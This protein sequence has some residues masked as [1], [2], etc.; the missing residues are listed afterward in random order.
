MDFL[1]WRMS[2]R[3]KKSRGLSNHSI[4]PQTSV[5]PLNSPEINTSYTFVQKGFE[6]LWQAVKVRQNLGARAPAADFAIFRSGAPAALR[7]IS[8]A[9]RSTACAPALFAIFLIKYRPKLAKEWVNNR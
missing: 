8:K 4:W 3:W 6:T 1:H 2:N 7:T 5:M 9:R